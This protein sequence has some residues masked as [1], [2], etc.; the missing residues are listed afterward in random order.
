MLC[1]GACVWFSLALVLGAGGTL[2]SATFSNRCDLFRGC[3]IVDDGGSTLGGVT[4]LCIGGSALGG[5][6]GL[7]V[8]GCTVGIGVWSY[9]PSVSCISC[10]VT[11][12]LVGYVGGGGGD[13]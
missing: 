7:C 3:T 1:S 10:V 4:I 5:S 11:P 8:V 12:L 13:F 6:A 9:C 2:G